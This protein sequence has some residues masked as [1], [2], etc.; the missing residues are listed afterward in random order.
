MQQRSKLD[1]HVDGSLRYL[2]TTLSRWKSHSRIRVVEIYQILQG[3][4]F[5][6]LQ[7]LQILLNLDFEISH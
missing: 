4:N 5:T 6:F 2:L 1:P 3:S 7:V